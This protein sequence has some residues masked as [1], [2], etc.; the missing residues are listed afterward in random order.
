MGATFKYEQIITNFNRIGAWNIKIEKEM[1]K[2]LKLKG[3]LR[4]QYERDPI[5]AIPKIVIA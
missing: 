2:Y 4:N 5:L 1:V 3:I